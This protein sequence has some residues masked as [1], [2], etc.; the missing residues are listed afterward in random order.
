M[1]PRQLGRRGIRRI[2]IVH[3]EDKALGARGWVTPCERRRHVVAFT[4]VA[5][6]NRAAGG[7]GG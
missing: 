2:G 4:S 6:R 3:D 5:L 1:H 7:E